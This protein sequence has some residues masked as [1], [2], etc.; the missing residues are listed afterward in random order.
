M[1]STPATV[2]S[3]VTL[4]TALGLA[5]CADLPRSTPP[6]SQPS[7]LDAPAPTGPVLPSAD[8]LSGVL[9]RLAD[10]SVPA[11]QKVALVQFATPVDQPALA[12][13][14][15]ALAANGFQPLTVDVSDLA[16]SGVPGQA[17]ATVTLGSPN[18]QA[19]PF[20]F[21][22]EFTPVGDGWQLGKRTADQLLPL[23]DAP[24]RPPG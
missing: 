17:M 6:P 22:M 19:H 8:V 11:E 24:A 7:A 20:T 9:L 1:P 2:L 12:N 16:W 14:G 23:V 13:F 21:P 18:P 3:A 15:E 10:T 4:V 5:G